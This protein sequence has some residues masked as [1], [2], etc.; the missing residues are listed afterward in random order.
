MV[1][2]WPL[3]SQPPPPPP[4][5]TH[6]HYTKQDKPYNTAVERLHEIATKAATVNPGLHMEVFIHKVDGDQFGAADRKIGGLALFF[7]LLLLPP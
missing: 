1:C 3:I 4:P 5:P 7:E 6:T 2:G